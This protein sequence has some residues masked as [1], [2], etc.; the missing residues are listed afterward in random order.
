M[1]IWPSHLYNIIV[2]AFTILWIWSCWLRTWSYWFRG[3][4]WWNP[5]HYT[6][7]LKK[8]S[9]FQAPSYGV[10]GCINSIG[11][12]LCTVLTYDARAVQ[13][14]SAE[15]R[16]LFYDRTKNCALDSPFHAHHP[17]LTAIKHPYQNVKVNP[18]KFRDFS[19]GCC[20]SSSSFVSLFHV[21]PEVPTFI[22]ALPPGLQSTYDI[23]IP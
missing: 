14:T 21:R 9:A 20:M 7:I 8:S 3:R 19:Q 12:F 23:L 15:R 11:C 13:I 5:T 17:R 6:C 4:V 2:F 22:K 1:V 18:A 10:D 16:R